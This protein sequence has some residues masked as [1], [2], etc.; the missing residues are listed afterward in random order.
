[1]GPG[2]QW[3]GCGD[4]GGGGVG[5]PTHLQAQ[6]VI[7]GA[8]DDVDGGG[9]ARLRAEVVLEVWG[10][11]WG[12]DGGAQPHGRPIWPRGC[13]VWPRG[14]PIWPHSCPIWPHSCPKWPHGHPI[15]PCGCPIRPRGHPVWP[16]GHPYVPMA[17]PHDVPVPLLCP[18]HS[19]CSSRNRSCVNSSSDITFSPGGCGGCGGYGGY[20]GI[21][22]DMGTVSHR[23]DTGTGGGREDNARWQQWGAWGHPEWHRA[24]P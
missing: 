24:T 11:R 1:M 3:G 17:A 15:W 21:W 14:C 7:H 2:R 9:V 4:V 20:G 5:G 18:S 6:Q 8:D 23:G 16:H 10:G 13:P 19:S 12:Q 22:G